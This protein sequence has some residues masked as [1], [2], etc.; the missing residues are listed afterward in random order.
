MYSDNSACPGV[1]AAILT[2]T[3]F[4]CG[5]L[6][7]PLRRMNFA[8]KIML[9]VAADY[10]KV[11]RTVDEVLEPITMFDRRAVHQ[12]PSVTRFCGITLK[13]TIQFSLH[14]HPAPLS[15]SH[16]A[17]VSLQQYIGNSKSRNCLNHN[18]GSATRILVPKSTGCK[19][20][21]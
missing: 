5:I 4:E 8:R 20:L 12:E 1:A 14:S 13:Y 21:I 9:R 10:R 11:S 19:A 7:Y 6:I 2:S 17:R 15:N 16:L 18:R 3:V